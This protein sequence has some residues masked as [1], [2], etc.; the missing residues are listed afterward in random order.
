[1]QEVNRILDEV[2]RDLAVAV[3]G[4]VAAVIG[5]IAAI[6]SRRKI[7]V[8]Q[9]QIVDKRSREMECA[10]A[11]VFLIAVSLGVGIWKLVV[12][13]ARRIAANNTVMKDARLKTIA[14]DL[15]VKPE[16][17]PNPMPKVESMIRQKPRIWSSVFIGLF[18]FDVVMDQVEKLR[19]AKA[20]AE[21]AEANRIAKEKADVEASIRKAA[22]DE[23]D[24]DRLIAKVYCRDDLHAII[25]NYPKTQAAK[26]AR[27]RLDK[28]YKN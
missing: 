23:R 4:L 24:A 16:P 27:E 20:N 18:A 12:D 8:H 10:F 21:K 5:L 3:V 1:M 17:K 13:D 25:I 2:G 15:T 22:E 14:S 19:T 11:F 28:L 9:K 7:V 6:I 26:K